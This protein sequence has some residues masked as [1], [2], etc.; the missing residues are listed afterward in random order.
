MKSPLDLSIS[1]PLNRADTAGKHYKS[2]TVAFSISGTS[3]QL[4][5]ICPSLRGTNDSHA[6]PL[7]NGTQPTGKP[8]FVIIR[9]VKTAY[10]IYFPIQHVFCPWPRR[11]IPKTVKFADVS[12]TRHACGLAQKVVSLLSH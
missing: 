6:N 11:N 5:A 9:R 7:K 12:V 1:S 10:S 3:K 4:W 2:P 8:W